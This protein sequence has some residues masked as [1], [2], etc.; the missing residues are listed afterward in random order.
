MQTAT[1][2]YQDYGISSLLDAHQDGFSPYFCDDG[3]PLFVA[4]DCAGRSKGGFP[5]PLAK[6]IAVNST[7][8]Q[9]NC[10]GVS[11]IP[12][13][14]LYFTYAV[15]ACF[16]DLYIHNSSLAATGF[17]AFWSDVVTAFAKAPN[18]AVLAY[19][20][21]N[22]PWSGDALRDPLLMVPGE[23]DKQ[24]LQPFYGRLTKVIRAAEKAAG[25][26]P[27]IIAM[28]P[29]VFDDFIPAGFSSPSDAWPATGKEMLAY[30]YYKL[31]NIEGPK[32]QV[33]YRYADARRLKASGILSEFDINLRNPVNPPYPKSVLRETM[34]ACDSVQHSY[35]GWYYSDMF[36]NS[37]FIDVEIA[38][39]LARPLPSVVSGSSDAKWVFDA[40]DENSPKFSLNY[41]HNIN[42]TT[43]VFLSTGL[44]FPSQSL[45]I[46]VTGD[47]I[48]WRIT[49]SK[50]VVAL[51]ASGIKA[52][53]APAVFDNTILSVYS[54]KTPFAPTA[55]SISVSVS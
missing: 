48:Q 53:P 9:P 52:V 54:T 16:D 15:G 49:P 14:E 27:R 22:E 51:P 3:S 1:K 19:E 31:P 12:W 36:V 5:E 11:G 46:K 25:I 43:T 29:V 2:L 38:R 7:T 18:G 41:T 33:E 40:S 42:S 37:S 47:G 17:D 55:V 35:I 10:S 8:L 6:P 30:H 23:A 32:L 24:R 44:W 20:L 34:D 21:L 4:A 26:S 50:G 13:S 28:E 45:Q 39:E